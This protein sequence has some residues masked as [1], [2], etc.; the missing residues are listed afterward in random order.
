MSDTDND[1]TVAAFAAGLP[2]TVEVFRRHGI[3]VCCGGHPSLQ[4][5]AEDAGVRM[6]ALRDELQASSMTPAVMALA[7]LGY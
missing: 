3:S 1:Q 6:E 4:E 7:T 2:G 5:A